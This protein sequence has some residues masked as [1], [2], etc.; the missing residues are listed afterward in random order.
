[1]KQLLSLTLLILIGCAGP[2]TTPPAKET[3]K[4]TIA[5]AGA[6]AARATAVLVEQA[7]TLDT[8]DAG[9]LAVVKAVALDQNKT[10]RLALGDVTTATTA[11]GKQADADAKV[12]VKQRDEL[13]AKPDAIKGFLVIA[14]IGLFVAAGALGIVAMLV[15]SATAKMKFGEAAAAA[16]ALGFIA[17]SIAHFLS[18]IYTI[19]I[20][21]VAAGVIF[22]AYLTWRFIHS[23]HAT[24]TSLINDNHAETVGL[25][26]AIPSA[27][28]PVA[29]GG[30]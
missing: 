27:V 14:S 10:A 18:T 11:A 7:A 29:G 20:A 22:L 2:A 8:L 4:G 19:T 25:I 30:P 16:L 28:A 24:T 1:M 5:D 3:T 23:N 12:I 17:A 21:I 15:P 9:N 6:A 26:Q 13:D